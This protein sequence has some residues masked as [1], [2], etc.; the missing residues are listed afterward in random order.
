[1]LN[2]TSC[3]PVQTYSTLCVISF[4]ADDCGSTAAAVSAFDSPKFDFAR[5]CCFDLCLDG[6]QVRLVSDCR[7][8]FG[9][10]A[11]LSAASARLRTILPLGQP[12][13]CD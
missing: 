10:V 6:K 12:H 8:Y 9:Q 4:G 3:V 1:M 2:Y 7:D 11:D 13:P 5:A